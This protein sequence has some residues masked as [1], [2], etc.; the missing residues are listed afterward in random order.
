MIRL[1]G[2]KT[3]VG[4][5][6]RRIAMKNGRCLNHGGKSTGPRTAEGKRRQIASITKSGRYSQKV[7]AEKRE[8]RKLLQGA[9]ELIQGVENLI[10]EGTSGKEE[11]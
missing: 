6:C 7:I 2:A 3:R 10:M 8:C 5:P 9:S 4:T 1:C 11:R